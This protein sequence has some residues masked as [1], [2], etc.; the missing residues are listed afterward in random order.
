MKKEKTPPPTQP[1]LG[2]V[3][4]PVWV[5]EGCAWKEKKP[6]DI[7]TRTSADCRRFT[8]G[9]KKETLPQLKQNITEASVAEWFIM[10]QTHLLAQWWKFHHLE[11][12]RFCTTL[13][14][15]PQG[16]IHLWFQQQE[17]SPDRFSLHLVSM[18]QGF[19]ITKKWGRKYCTDHIWL[20]FPSVDGTGATEGGGSKLEGHCPAGH[21]LVLFTGTYLWTAWK[22]GAFIF[23]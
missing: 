20:S 17:E 11:H 4:L 5:E 3:P 9:R 13:G 18:I 23:R 22:P 2:P 21:L 8:V 1:E 14:N 7:G 19:G 12:W 15:T 10:C 16:I 6:S